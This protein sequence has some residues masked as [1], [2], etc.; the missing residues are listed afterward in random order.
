MK[1][2]ISLC[3][4]FTAYFPKNVVALK[5]FNKFASLD[6]QFANQIFLK[7]IFVI[8]NFFDEHV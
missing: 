8:F 4:H 2:G 6:G 3:I 1:K 5:I 7:L